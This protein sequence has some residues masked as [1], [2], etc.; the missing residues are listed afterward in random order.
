MASQILMP[1]SVVSFAEAPSLTQVSLAFVG[2]NFFEDSIDPF[3]ISYLFRPP[4]RP[5]VNHHNSGVTI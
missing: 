1:F 5:I 4:K 2:S 3:R